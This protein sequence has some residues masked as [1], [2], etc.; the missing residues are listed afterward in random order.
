MCGSGT[1]RARGRVAAGRGAERGSALVATLVVFTG[2]LGMV[3]L[4]TLTSIEE[5]KASRSGVD[6]VRV[7]FTAEAGVE[8]G[9]HFLKD[10][11]KKTNSHDPIAGLVGLFGGE[12][13]VTLY[14]GEPL[15]DGATQVGA[16]SVSMT[17]AAEDADSITIRLDVTGYLPDAPMNLGPD[18]QVRAWESLEVMVRF[19]LQPSRVF[20]FGY[21]VNNWGWFYGNTI[22][23]NG[24]AGGNGQFD[25]AGYRP[26]V[27]GQPIYDGLDWIGAHTLLNGYHDD[28]EDGAADGDDGGIFAGWD[29]VGTQSVRGVGGQ[30]QNQHDF[31]DPIDMPNLTDLSSYEATAIAEGSGI[32]IGGTQVSDPVFGDD[33][34]ETG[35]LYL[36]GT[37]ANPIVIDGPVIVRGDLIISGY[38][39][40]QGSIYTEGNIYVPDSIQYSRGPNM[41]RPTHNTQAV[42]EAWLTANQN[43]DFLGLFAR[44]N[45]VVGDFTDPT[46]ERYVENWMGSSMNRSDEDAGEDGIPNTAPGRDGSSGTADDDVLEDDGEFTVEY[47]SDADAELGLI[48][49]GLAVGDAIPGSGEDIDGD[50]QYDGPTT[51]ADLTLSTALDNASW[52]GNLPVGGYAD[53]SDIATLDANKLEAVFYT[54]HSFCYVVLGSRTAEIN[55]GLVCRN[56]NIIYGTPTLEINYDSRLLGGSTSMIQNLLP[57][58]MPTAQVLSWRRQTSDPNRYLELP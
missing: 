25:A 27:T 20:D 13:S 23:C 53:Y 11:V 43:R 50:G 52:G 58:S 9:I 17:N 36:R 47:Y 31:E 21:F 2:L 8:R 12:E 54:N 56:E 41:P 3:Y 45:I 29:V 48:P 10:A 40:G 22:E 34:G 6:E 49:P 51:M 4:T 32:S 57:K 37:A 55:G 15:L 39:S 14:A 33:G 16:Y 7:K 18:Q 26:S 38:V 46:W 44:E 28:N 19:E 5:A 42:T 1:R 24:N 30:D 35:N